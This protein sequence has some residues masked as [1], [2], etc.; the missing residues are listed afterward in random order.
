MNNIVCKIDLFSTQQQIYLLYE[1]GGIENTINC[2]LT[3]LGE[4]LAQLAL[5]K[6]AES[7]NI[8]GSSTYAQK[9]VKDLRKNINLI[10]ANP[11]LVLKVNGNEICY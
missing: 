9:I 6:N 1:T 4:T 8:M 10:N 5:N 3:T 7:I 11:N 2:P